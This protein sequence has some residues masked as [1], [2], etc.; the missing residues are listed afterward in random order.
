MGTVRKEAGGATS[1]VG[2]RA[3]RIQ[4]AGKQGATLGGLGWRSGW[5]SFI[6]QEQTGWGASGVVEARC[7]RPKINGR[8]PA[9]GRKAAFVF[10]A[11]EVGLAEGLEQS[12]GIS[13]ACAVEREHGKGLGRVLALYI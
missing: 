2:T 6:E 12:G 1:G 10:A 9:A 13:W 5:R 4:E 3:G 11:I 8:W 7:V